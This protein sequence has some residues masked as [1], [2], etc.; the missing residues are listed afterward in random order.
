MGILSIDD[1]ST[2]T[3]VLH[4][5]SRYRDRKRFK[6]S[7]LFSID[8][9]PIIT[10]VKAIRLSS[11]EF[12]NIF[13][14]ISR[15][16]LNNVFTVNGSE[17]E[18][19]SGNYTA[20][21]MICAIQDALDVAFDKGTY[22][23]TFSEITGRVTIENTKNFLFKLSD[24]RRYVKKYSSRSVEGDKI[25]VP[26]L[27][28]TIGFRDTV[29]MNRKKYTSESV[30][31]VVGPNYLIMRVNDFGS[32]RYRQYGMSNSFAKIILT[33]PKATA[34]F[35]NY[36]NFVSKQ[37]DFHQPVDI[38]KLKIQLI[39]PYEDTVNMMG[40]DYSMTFELLCV[41]NYFVKKRLEDDL[42]WWQG[43]FPTEEEENVQEDDL[44]DV[45]RY[46]DA[47]EEEIVESSDNV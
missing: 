42:V 3:V 15:E 45:L 5:D 12:P 24:S 25:P 10:N 32:M 29:Y 35:D 7:G 20:E 28:Y 22:D 1:V 37:H 33:N 40:L 16:K 4:V 14:S 41:R 27:L 8:L 21:T 23:I 38:S 43:G 30:I 39:D 46:S 11:L 18:V 17:I 47:E 6:N 13:Y 26:S 9:N 34:T 36:S 31:D 19:E 44:G 2:D